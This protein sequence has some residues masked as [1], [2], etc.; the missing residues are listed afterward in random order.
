MSLKPSLTNN[1]S[2]NVRVSF[3]FQNFFG[4]LFTVPFK[5]AARLNLKFTIHTLHRP[6]TLCHSCQPQ[7][8]LQLETDYLMKLQWF[9]NDT[10]NLLKCIY[11]FS[12]TREMQEWFKRSTFPSMSTSNIIVPQTRFLCSIT[13][14]VYPCTITS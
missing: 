14:F 10:I 1:K 13:P 2:K 7:L 8:G 4:G 5:L 11:S 12:S 6:K 9:K 3:V